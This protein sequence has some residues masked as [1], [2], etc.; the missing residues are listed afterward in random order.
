M[1]PAIELACTIAGVVAGEGT[2]GHAAGRRFRFAISLAA[3]DRIVCELLHAYFA[4]GRIHTSPRRREHYDDE[5]TY[6]V[7]RL[8]DLVEVIVPFMDEHL[9]PSHK[10][11]Q[12]L[13]WREQLLDYWENRARR[14]RPCTVD[15]CEAPRRAKGVCRRHYYERFGC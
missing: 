5:V 10:R 7:Q 3:T 11:E 6:Q 9:P 2:F 8:R 13:V 15:G 12:Y 1:S 4:V 14:R